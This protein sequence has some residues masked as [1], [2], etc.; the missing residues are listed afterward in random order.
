V[1]SDWRYLSVTPISLGIFASAN[2]SATTSYESIA[3]ATLSGIANAEFTSIPSTY[4]HLQLRISAIGDSGSGVDSTMRFNSDANSNYRWHRIYGNGTSA[5]AQAAL[6]ARTEM[7]VASDAVRTT[8]PT[9]S[10]ID[11]L[12]YADTNKYKTA[13][14]LTGVDNNGSGTITL[15]SGLWMSTN[16]ITS[17]KVTIG[18]G[19]FA[20]GSHFALYGIKGA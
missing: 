10:V 6:S 1:G 18:S 5:A 7:Y 8:Y 9:V 17:L 13:R 4:K 11:I 3:T 2:Q 20:S 16:A 12:D 15:W 19:N 14:I